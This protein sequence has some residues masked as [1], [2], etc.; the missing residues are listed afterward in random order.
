MQEG[1]LI[2]RSGSG[3]KSTLNRHAIRIVDVGRRI[4]GRFGVHSHYGWKV[5]H[6]RWVLEHDLAEYAPSTRYDYWL[7]IRR[8]V[9]GRQRLDAWEKY[10]IGPWQRPDGVTR[11]KGAGGK[12]AKLPMQ[13]SRPGS[14]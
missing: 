7:A 12:K 4:R 14:P 9:A 8:Y 5:S 13:V 11:P 1:D 2:L 3:K 10:L 6:L